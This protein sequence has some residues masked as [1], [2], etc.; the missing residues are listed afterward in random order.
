MSSVPEAGHSEVGAP[1]SPVPSGLLTVPEFEQLVQFSNRGDGWAFE[2]EADSIGRVV[3]EMLVLNFPKME[4]HRPREGSYRIASMHAA[5]ATYTDSTW[6][7]VH[8]SKS[9]TIEQAVDPG[10]P[11]VLSDLELKIP[12]Q[13]LTNLPKHCGVLILS[14]GEG[15]TVNVRSGSLE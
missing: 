10:A 13:D 3:D 7:T 9:V 1:P 15:G 14:N 11:R 5:I 12:V 2:L 8:R 6:R 4:I